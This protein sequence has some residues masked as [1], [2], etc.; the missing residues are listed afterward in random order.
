M[1]E[2]K[3]TIGL[4]PFTVVVDYQD[5]KEWHVTLF[6]EEK[7]VYQTGWKNKECTLEAF[8]EILDDVRKWRKGSVEELVMILHDGVEDG[9]YWDLPF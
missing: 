2:T 5:S 3:K 6:A 1:S 9:D 4:L 7:E 8:L